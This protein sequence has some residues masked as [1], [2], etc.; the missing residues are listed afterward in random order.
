MVILACAET[1]ETVPSETVPSL[2]VIV[3]VG[4]YGPATLGRTFVVM[5]TGCESKAGLSELVVVTNVP[6][7]L[8][9]MLMTFPLPCAS[10]TSGAPSRLKSPVS[11]KKGVVLGQTQ[12]EFAIVPLGQFRMLFGARRQLS[13][14]VKPVD[15]SVIRQTMDEATIALRIFR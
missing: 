15:T 6:A 2:K 14:T 4:E 13:L 10:A 9:R 3:P 8:S 11:A 12:D 1:R 7:M 5:V